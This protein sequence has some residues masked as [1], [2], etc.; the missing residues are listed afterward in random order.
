[1]CS[2]L[3]LRSSCSGFVRHWIRKEIMA[4]HDKRTD[5][6]QIEV[7]MPGKDANHI[8]SKCKDGRSFAT[9]MTPS[10]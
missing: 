9:K 4:S 3:H 10:G 1:M 6:D 2:L 8:L 7:G 5:S